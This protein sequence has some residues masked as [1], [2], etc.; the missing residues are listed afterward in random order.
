MQELNPAELDAFYDVLYEIDFELVDMVRLF[1]LSLYKTSPSE[2]K[3][4]N[5][6]VLRPPKKSNEP[7]K[8]EP[9]PNRLKIADVDPSERAKLVRV[10]LEMIAR[11]KRKYILFFFVPI[12]DTSP[13][14]WLL[15]Y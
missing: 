2:H 15:Y 9:I 6:L 5:H 11:G 4:F 12:K 1:L 3:M 7:E 8:L 14:Q 13:Y 10:G